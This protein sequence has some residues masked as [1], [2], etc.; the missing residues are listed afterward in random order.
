MSLSLRDDLNRLL[1]LTD[2]ARRIVSLSPA[3]TENLFAVGAGRLVVGIT[4]ADTYPPEALKLP[5]VGD[6]GT[7]RY[8][9]LRALKPDLIIA[10]SGTLRADA[11][12]NIA[13]RAGAP[14]FA[15]VSARYAD[16]E[17]HL[18]QLATL[19][20]SGKGPNRHIV[21][22]RF[23]ESEARRV[24]RGKKPVSTFLEVS[25]SPLYAAGVGSFLDDVLRLAGGVNVIR[26]PNPYP[27]V[28]RE[29]L[30]LADPQVY[31]TTVSGA[32]EQ[33]RPGDP[34]PSPLNHIRA[35][36]T[37]RVYALPIDLLFRPTPRLARG[38]L[39]LSRALHGGI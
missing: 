21:S 18:R 39:L 34:L 4:A 30:L 20:G 35:A 9:T 15:Q 31:I 29:T 26:T 19:A 8:E 28:S 38:L 6:F 23:A 33:I 17:R 27:M 3:A 11:L 10:E 36:K 14:V 12:R 22:L 1:T 7:P 5:R 25:R 2:P 16:I 32:T 24:A 37:N 13:D